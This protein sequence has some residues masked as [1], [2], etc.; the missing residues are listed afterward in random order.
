MLSLRV[1][2]EMG[3]DEMN[4]FEWFDLWCERH[5]NLMEEED[6]GQLVQCCRERYDRDHDDTHAVEALAEAYVLNMQNQDAIDLLTPYYMK[7]SEHPLYAHGILD[8]LL[9]M[10]KQIEDFPWKTRPK[11]LP[12][13]NDVLDT[14]YEHLKPKRV[15]RNPVDLYFLFMGSAYLLFSEDDLVEALSADGR[16][17]VTYDRGLTKISVARKRG[18]R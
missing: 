7:D 15:P 11:V 18:K 17:V 12:L 1:G 13:T 9:A 4:E 5:A 10:C 8:A 3:Q 16:F 14:C 6:Y 2:A